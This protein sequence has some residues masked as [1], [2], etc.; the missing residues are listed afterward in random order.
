VLCIARVAIKPLLV[1]PHRR[2][3][4]DNDRDLSAGEAR[5]PPGTAGCLEELT[6]DA[7]NLGVLADR[8]PHDPGFSSLLRGSHSRTGYLESCDEGK[9]L[10]SG[11]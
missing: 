3:T 7:Q 10:N 9:P 4:E 5:L 11:F 2:R 6:G 8:D 1:G